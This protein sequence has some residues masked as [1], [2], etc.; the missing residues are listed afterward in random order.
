MGKRK[1]VVIGS[2]D[3]DQQREELKKKKEAKK[4]EQERAEK[5]ERDAENMS[6]EHGT[7]SKT[8][9][10]EQVTDNQKDDKDAIDESA[11]K[12]TD[13][14][15]A[16]LDESVESADKKSVAS[17]P[18]KKKVKQGKA[19]VRSK[20]YQEKIALVNREKLYEKDEAIKLAKETSFTKFD[21]TIEV[22]LNLGIDS[23][24]TD[25][26]LRTVITLPSTFGKEKTV[27]VVANE[28]KEKEAKTAGAKHVG[29]ENLINEI[30]KG[31]IK[32]DVLIATPDMM[33][34]LGKIA[35]ILGP[36]GLMPN[37][38]LGTVTENVANAV[39]AQLGGQ[40]E[41]KNDDSGNIHFA[42]GK[43]SMEDAKIKENLEY[44]LSTVNENKPQSVKKEYIKS[45]TICSTMGPGVKVSLK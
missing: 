2:V 19:K 34:K 14:N 4:R 43:A 33:P 30:E 26:N 3:E 13:D 40:K 6:G 29:G 41:L 10:K 45:I 42:I 5:K 1:G 7:E 38:K 12:E 32:I 15:V 25:Q 21:A 17:E 35:K 24:K 20:K 39:K 16:S 23:S 27:A 31:K 37:P 36:K 22:H 18:Q 9:D 11:E 44:F 8:I 28:V